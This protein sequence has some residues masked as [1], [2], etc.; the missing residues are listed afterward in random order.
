MQKCCVLAIC[1]H[2]VPAMEADDW[3]Q[4]LGT[5]RC[6]DAMTMLVGSVKSSELRAVCVDEATFVALV[7]GLADPNPR[8][9]WWCVQLLDH[10]PDER[11]FD[12]LIPVLDDPVPRVRRN[13]AHAMGCRV[14]KPSWDGS[15]PEEALAR[16]RALAHSDSSAKV[17]GEALQALMRSQ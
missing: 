12:A 5:H 11:T 16:L 14:C 4:Q 7:D 6:L 3:V 17:R 13:A 8:I 15:L 10:I 9:R 1:G 2:S